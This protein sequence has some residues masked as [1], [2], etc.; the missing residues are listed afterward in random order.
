MQHPVCTTRGLELQISVE[1]DQLY[2]L[3]CV[4]VE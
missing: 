1:L 4:N 2:V 3:L